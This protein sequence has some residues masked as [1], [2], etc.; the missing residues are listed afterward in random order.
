[1]ITLKNKVYNPLINKLD[2]FRSQNI[3][4]NINA[5]DFMDGLY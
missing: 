3:N 2:I 4:K 5:E 1:M